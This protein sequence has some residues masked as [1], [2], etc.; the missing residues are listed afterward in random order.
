MLDPRNEMFMSIKKRNCYKIGGKICPDLATFIE[1]HCCCRVCTVLWYTTTFTI[2]KYVQYAMQLAFS[3]SW[4]L[5]C[6]FLLIDNLWQAVMR[7]LFIFQK[8]LC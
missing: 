5:C 6:G 8:V 2:V 4:W 1:K 3:E 7:E